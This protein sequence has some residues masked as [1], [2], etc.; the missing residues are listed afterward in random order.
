[1]TIV[2]LCNV[3]GIVSKK[4]KISLTSMPI[5]MEVETK[6]QHENVTNP[7]SNYYVVTIMKNYS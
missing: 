4:L 6:N 5:S 1:M 3:C 2:V 7:P